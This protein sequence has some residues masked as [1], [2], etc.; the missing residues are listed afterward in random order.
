MKEV[1]CHIEV[2]GYHLCF[3]ISFRCR[4]DVSVRSEVSFSFLP[5]ALETCHGQGG[6]TLVPWIPESK[7]SVICAA[8]V[9][10]E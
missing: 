1:R 6:A 5:N 2:R 7:H 3:R 10:R 9:S 4:E 8:S